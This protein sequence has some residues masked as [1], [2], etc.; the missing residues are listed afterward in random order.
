MTVNEDGFFDSHDQNVL[1]YNRIPKTGSSSMLRMLKALEVSAHKLKFVLNSFECKGFFPPA[2]VF[3]LPRCWNLQTKHSITEEA[4]EYKPAD[5]VCQ[6]IRKAEGAAF[7]QT[8]FCE[9]PCPLHR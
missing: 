5:D 1:L 9:Q 6:E 3:Q 7:P 2:S 4:F 8:H